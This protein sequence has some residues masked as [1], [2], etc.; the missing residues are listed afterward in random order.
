MKKAVISILLVGCICMFSGCGESV[1]EADVLSSTPA[2][3]ETAESAAEQSEVSIKPGKE[4]HLSKREVDN[5]PEDSVMFDT[6][7]TTVKD[8]QMDYARLDAET[9][10]E[11]TFSDTARAKV[12]EYNDSGVEY[13]AGILLQEDSFLVCDKTKGEIVRLSYEGERLAS[14]GS[15][16]NQEGQFYFPI[17]IREWDG[18]LY[19]LDSGNARIQVFDE[20]MTYI[21]SIGYEYGGATDMEFDSKGNLYLA[22][23]PRMG[24]NACVYYI[25]MKNNA[26][27]PVK[28]AFAC[29][30]GKDEEHVYAV[31]LFEIY[32]EKSE[33]KYGT[34]YSYM[35]YASGAA[36]ML[37][38]DDGEVSKEQELIYDYNVTDFA[39][40]EGDF[41]FAGYKCATPYGYIIDR[42]KAP[43]YE[44]IESYE[45][46]GNMD[47][48][49]YIDIGEDGTMVTSSRS[50]DRE[51]GLITI[52]TR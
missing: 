41:Y 2:D 20:D 1:E 50:M 51:Y 7:G 21:C 17:Q 3:S 36:F 4:I 34:Y 25:D 6:E 39:D 44:Y 47:Q 5:P 11:R 27:M 49:G 43:D 12:L 26:I 10:F 16:G 23:D 30:L 28:G 42:A 18:N 46:C 19:V 8:G 35:G 33:N 24:V 15:L 37:T 40:Y 29:S 31:S 14:Y 32:G 38:L 48:E 13:P 9:G 45:L 22:L 52:V